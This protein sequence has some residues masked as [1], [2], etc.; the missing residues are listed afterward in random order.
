MNAS[1]KKAHGP[2][3]VQTSQFAEPEEPDDPT[4]WNPGKPLSALITFMEY[5]D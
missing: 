3:P 4:P 5:E 1:P 2:K